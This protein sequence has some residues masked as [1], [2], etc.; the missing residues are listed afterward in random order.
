MSR[1]GGYKALLSELKN[2]A[3]WYALTEPKTAELLK[4]AA[5][6]IE[7]S[8][9]EGASAEK[10]SPKHWIPYPIGEVLKEL[11]LGA[12]KKGETLND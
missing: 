3:E 7:K 1:S 8:E 5:E 12:K 11:E 6:A 4:R 10:A 2:A 9:K